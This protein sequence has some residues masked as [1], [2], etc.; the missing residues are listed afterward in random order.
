MVIWDAI[1]PIMTVMVMI[2]LILHK[3][4]TSAPMYLCKVSLT[5]FLQLISTKVNGQS[6]LQNSEISSKKI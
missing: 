4:T 2:M 3:K 1:V 5:G 6:E